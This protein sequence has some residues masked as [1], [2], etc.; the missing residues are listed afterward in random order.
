MNFVVV[1]V[2]IFKIKRISHAKENIMSFN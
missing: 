1:V 2:G